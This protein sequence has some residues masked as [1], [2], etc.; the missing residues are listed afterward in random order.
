MVTLM[1]SA[2]RK[3]VGMINLRPLGLYSILMLQYS[4]IK[5]HIEKS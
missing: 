5:S 4:L 1:T 3:R 2:A